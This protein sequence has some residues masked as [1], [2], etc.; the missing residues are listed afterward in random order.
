M[1]VAD[2]GDGEGVYTVV[3]PSGERLPIVA[4]DDSGLSALR[5]YSQELA[6]ISGTSVSIISFT[7]RT[8]HETFS[9]LTT[10]DKET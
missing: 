4:I 3:G 2:H 7:Q 6:N 5:E 8:Q 9:P 10:G 1:A